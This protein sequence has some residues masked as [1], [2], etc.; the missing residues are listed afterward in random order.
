[1][2]GFPAPVQPAGHCT[3]HDP[4]AARPSGRSGAGWPYMRSSRA[5]GGTFPAPVAAA[6]VGPAPFRDRR[7]CADELVRRGAAYRRIIDEGQIWPGLGARDVIGGR[8]TISDPRA[9]D[10]PGSRPQD[11]TG[12][13]DI[14]VDRPRMGHPGG[15]GRRDRNARPAG[16]RGGGRRRQKGVAVSSGRLRPLQPETRPGDIMHRIARLD[17]GKAVGQFDQ[18][19]GP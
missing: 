17:I 6:A 11:N 3:S 1:M 16:A 5:K 7:Q 19:V 14:R 8:T 9:A 12:R 4:T 18:P 2:S 10:Q 13:D 15:A